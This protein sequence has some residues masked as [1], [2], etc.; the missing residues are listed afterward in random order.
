MTVARGK[1]E[2]DLGEEIECTRCREYWPA[3]SEFFHKG[4][5]GLHTW[6][7]ACVTASKRASRLRNQTKAEA[8]E[9]PSEP[10]AA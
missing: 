10:I 9:Q 4:H 5:G 1:I 6:C 8:A 2:T 3:D 7:K